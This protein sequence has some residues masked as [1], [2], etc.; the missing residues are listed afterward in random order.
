MFFQEGSSVELRSP[1]AAALYLAGRSSPQ[2]AG[3]SSPADQAAVLQHCFYAQDLGHVVASWVA[4]T[5]VRLPR[6]CWMLNPSENGL[7]ETQVS[8]AKLK[9]ICV[10]VVS[11][12]CS[13]Y[14]YHFG[15]S[16]ALCVKWGYRIYVHVLT[17]PTPES[18]RMVNPKMTSHISLFAV[19]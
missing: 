14:R 2:L 15:I 18:C 3:G 13:E 16:P 4:P 12:V 17:V 9:L 5:Q 10:Q 8:N 6:R 11:K 1:L 19:G 7:L